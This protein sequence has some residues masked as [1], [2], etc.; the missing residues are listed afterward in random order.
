ML[1][2]GL[3]LLFWRNGFYQLRWRN[4]FLCSV[5]G[6]STP[7]A[8]QIR[9]RLRISGFKV[10]PAGREL[11]AGLLVFPSVNR[12]KKRHNDTGDIHPTIHRTQKNRQWTAIFSGHA[13]AAYL[14]GPRRISSSFR[15]LPRRFPEFLSAPSDSSKFS[16]SIPARTTTGNS[17]HL[18][19]PTAPLFCPPPLLKKPLFFCPSR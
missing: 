11:P 15:A 10:C 12:K 1:A 13:A 3:S 6:G 4:N 9:R 18:H 19:S 7:S 14:F 5:D 17:F 2:E 16:L 8:N